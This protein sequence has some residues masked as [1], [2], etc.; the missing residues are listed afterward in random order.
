MLWQLMKAGE[1]LGDRNMLAAETIADDMIA[2]FSAM[3]LHPGADMRAAIDAAGKC[4]AMVF[5]GEA[6]A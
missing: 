4:G 1:K 6:P 3:H 5:M 2:A